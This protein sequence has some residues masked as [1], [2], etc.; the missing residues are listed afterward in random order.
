L[1]NWGGVGE[2]LLGGSFER[3]MKR[4][5]CERGLVGKQEELF[6]NESTCTIDG[7]V[8]DNTERLS[9]LG[10]REVPDRLRDR[11][12]AIRVP[13][14]NHGQDGGNVLKSGFSIPAGPLALDGSLGWFK[15][16]STSEGVPAFSDA[17]YHPGECGYG[18]GVCTHAIPLVNK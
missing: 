13:D 12:G 11:R 3:E 7:D 1:N 14:G 2:E 18:L 15:I 16:S 6:V 10:Q 9:V 4:F 8:G 17:L 5:L